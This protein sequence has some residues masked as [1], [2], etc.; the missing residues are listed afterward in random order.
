MVPPMHFAISPANST[1]SSMYFFPP[2]QTR[3]RR[4]LVT[5]ADRDQNRRRN[6]LDHLVG[7]LRSPIQSAV[8]FAACPDDREV[9]LVRG[10][11]G[12]DLADRL[13]GTDHNI[14]ENLLFV[15]HRCF[16]LERAPERLLVA[17]V[18][19]NAKQRGLRVARSGDESP[20]P[21]WVVGGIGAVA[22]NEDA[23]G[24]SRVCVR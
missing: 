23:H 1:A 16:A 4:M 10:R 11:L 8:A 5:G 14:R 2:V 3:M 9:V 20:K 7:F 12:Q 17:G 18:L 6:R 13:A 15:E 19:D 21:R 24:A 22:A